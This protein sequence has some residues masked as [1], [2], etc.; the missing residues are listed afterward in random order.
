MNFPD[1]WQDGIP[2]TYLAG[3]AV[4]HTDDIP[5]GMVHRQVPTGTY[6]VVNYQGPLDDIGQIW[7]FF[8]RDWLPNSAYTQGDLVQFEF[9]QYEENWNSFTPETCQM[10]VWFPVAKK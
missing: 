3:V 2:F 10:T 7:Q 8:Y 5:E 4:S 6:G 9:E 1:N